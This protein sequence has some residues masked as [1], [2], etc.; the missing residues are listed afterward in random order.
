MTDEIH[1]FGINC[2]Q[3][4]RIRSKI[5][6]VDDRGQ[7][8]P[9]FVLVEMYEKRKKDRKKQGEKNK[10]EKKREKRKKVFKPAF[11]RVEK[12]KKEKEGAKKE[13]TK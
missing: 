13:K 3:L 2:R 7:F 1:R 8:K 12:E 5:L 4:G 10:E 9:A 6:E 11:V